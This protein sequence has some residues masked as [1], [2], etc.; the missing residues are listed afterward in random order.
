VVGGEGPL[1]SPEHA[2]IVTYQLTGD[3]FGETYESD[4][5]HALTARLSVAI[6]SAEAGELDGG[7]FGGGEVTL[8]A[9]GSNASRLFSTMEPYLRAFPARPAHAVLRFGEAGDVAAAE[10]RVEL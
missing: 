6:E 4:V 5:V 7:E 8:Y 1:A 10:Q 2:V 9:F 3:G